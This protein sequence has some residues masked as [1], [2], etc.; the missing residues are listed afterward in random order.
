MR[1]VLCMALLVALNGCATKPSPHADEVTGTGANAARSGAPVSPALA[2]LRT[3]AE[4][5][6]AG[7]QQR[8]GLAYAVGDGVMPDPRESFKWSQKAAENGDAEGQYQLAHCFADGFGTARNLAEAA[9]W[10]RQAAEQ[11]HAISQLNLGFCCST[12]NGVA[13][14]DAEAVR[15]FRKAAEQGVPEAQSNLALCLAR[16]DGVA[17]DF[18]EAVKWYHR[19]AEQGY[20]DAQASLG[21]SYFTGEGVEKNSTEG[22]R[23][24]RTAAEQG[25]ARGQG[26]LGLCYFKGEGV[27]QD[28]VEA[29]K[30]FTLAARQGYAKALTE[31]RDAIEHFRLTQPQIAEAERRAAEFVPMPAPALFGFASA[32]MPKRAGT[33]FFITDDGYLMTSFHVVAGAMR[34]RVRTGEGTFPAMLVR[35]DAANDLAILKIDG[36][37][38]GLPL[39]ASRNVKLGQAVFTIG[40]PN[41]DWQG[42]E[43]KLTK[44]EISSLAGMHD[45]PRQ[46][47]V[48]VATQPGN[49]GGPLVDERGNVVGVLAAEANDVMLLQATGSLPQNVNYAVKSAYALALLG[50][51]PE[52]ASKLKAS[53][54]RAPIRNVRQAGSSFGSVRRGLLSA[55]DSLLHGLSI[56]VSPVGVAGMILFMG[57]VFNPD[58]VL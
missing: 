57:V 30:W 14:D 49:S 1:T 50:D 13:K 11:G 54:A 24:T 43:P 56:W 4:K 37:S 27:P 34:V 5:G 38:H 9:R 35:A 17:Q 28:G 55:M 33:G 12:G 53:N 2:E 10:Y 44:G 51:M 48:S 52:L 26:N 58:V 20:A 22:V 36:P 40:F 3:R 16:G 46:F 8:L 15:W 19:A 23:W 41:P 21:A 25:H 18:A 31:G 29:L 47:Q 6:D 32:L 39:V 42:L 7:A 45:D